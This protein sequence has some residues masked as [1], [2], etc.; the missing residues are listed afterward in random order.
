MSISHKKPI[1]K[2]RGRNRKSRCK[3]FKTEELANAWAKTNNVGN[4]KLISLKP[5]SKTG[6]FKIEY[7]E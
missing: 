3:S 5:N 4:Y 7:T 6:K 2:H 1:L